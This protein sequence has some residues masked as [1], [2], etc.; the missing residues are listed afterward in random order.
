MALSKPIA[1]LDLAAQAGLEPIPLS[2]VAD[3]NPATPEISLIGEI[4]SANAYAYQ[5]Q[6]QAGVD[7]RFATLLDQSDILGDWAALVNATTGQV[8]WANELAQSTLDVHSDSS[9]PLLL[10]QP[11]AM[12]LVV[13]NLLQ[14]VVNPFHVDVHADK[15]VYADNAVYRFNLVG[16]GTYFYTVNEAEKNYV[17][18]TYKDAAR[19]EGVA[20]YGEDEARTGYVPVYRFVK[21]GSFFYTAKENEKEFLLQSHPEYSFDGVG[22][23][24][25]AQESS[26]TEPVYRLSNP[27]S[28]NYLFTASPAEKLYALLQGGWQDDGIV[29]QALKAHQTEAV[30]AAVEAP[31]DT[32]AEVQLIG[33]PE[34]TSDMVAI[35]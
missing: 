26:T 9:A 17:L 22:F 18:E 12:T 14:G 30:P 4:N 35:A 3:G 11:E 34:G 33:V 25:P 10:Q 19:Y 21:N 23:Y 15:H 8:Y 27:E 20:F 5:F 2:L 24:V 32:P 1:W 29:F 6:L 31:A 28:G 16:N 13:R 7:Y